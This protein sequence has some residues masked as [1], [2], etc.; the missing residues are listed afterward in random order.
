LLGR[1]EVLG[2]DVEEAVA[3]P[4][5]QLRRR[6]VNQSRFVL[7]RHLVFFKTNLSNKSMEDGWM[8]GREALKREPR[9]SSDLDLVN[10]TKD[11]RRKKPPLRAKATSREI[12]T[13]GRRTFAPQPIAFFSSPL[14]KPRIY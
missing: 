6:E 1:P 9:A 11:Q 5:F 12:S 10:T 4:R 3:L 7:G 8:E 13:A 2:L 14:I